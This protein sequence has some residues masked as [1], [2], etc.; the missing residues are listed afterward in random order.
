MLTL[1]ATRP[2]DKIHGLY[3][4]CKGFGFELPAP[5]YHKP[6]AAVYTEAAQGIIRYDQGLELL[7]S[8][9]ESSGWEWGLPSWVPS[10]SG[11]PRKWSPSNPPHVA[12][13]GKGSPAVSGRTGWKH[14]FMLDR[15]ALRVRGRR[16]DM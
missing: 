10:F 15:Q 1:E 16:L 12:I 13:A 2:E 5:N 6:V 7:S 3:N 4:I 11:C 9:T 8:V 14:E